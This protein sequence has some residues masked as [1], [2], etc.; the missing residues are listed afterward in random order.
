MQ[1]FLFLLF[2]R[3]KFKTWKYCSPRGDFLRVIFLIGPSFCLHPLVEK[4]YFRF[5]D[6]KYPS[7]P[8]HIRSTESGT[9][10]SSA[11]I[12]KDEWLNF[13]QDIRDSKL[14]SPLTTFLLNRWRQTNNYETINWR[15]QN[16]NSTLEGGHSC[17]KYMIKHWHENIHTLPKSTAKKSKRLPI[18]LPW[19]G[20]KPEFLD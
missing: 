10:T 4:N 9:C 3:P 6:E 18:K 20:T 17:F 16:Y 11:G 14:S 2:Y 15:T 7:K 1:L 13:L 5:R 8:N 19:T 12:S